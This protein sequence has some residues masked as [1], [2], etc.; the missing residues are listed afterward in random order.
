M[1]VHHL[2]GYK[3]RDGV[4]AVGCISNSGLAALDQEFRVRTTLVIDCLDVPNYCSDL[5]LSNPK[6]SLDIACKAMSVAAD[7]C[8]AFYRVGFEA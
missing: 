6:K 1:P 5:K 2:I 4:Q 7:I 8:L 3:Y